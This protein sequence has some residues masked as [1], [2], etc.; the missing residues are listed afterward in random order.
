MSGE[1]FGKFFLRLVVGGLMLFHGISKLRHGI[2]PI[3]Q[4]VLSHGLPHPVAYLV[5]VG[6]VV[7]P[8]LIVVGFWARPA[9]LAIVV[10]MIFAVWLSHT[11]D[12]WHVGKGG[13]YA[14]EL[15][16]F[17]LFG[18]LAVMLLGAGRL[19]LSKGVGKLN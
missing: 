3:P 9:A 7:A 5:Y 6:E 19:S 10:N 8:L 13:G 14:L 12:L 1:D 16:A 15:Q 4:M 17:Y 11:H 2:A 18:G